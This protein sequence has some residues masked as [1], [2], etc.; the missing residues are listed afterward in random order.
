MAVTTFIPELWS[1]RLKYNLEKNLV[2]ANLV[3]RDY[4]GEIRQAGDTVH[5]NN[6]NP[7]TIRTYAAGTPITVEDL[8]TTDTDLVIS[9]QDYFAFKVEDIDKAQ[10]A[11]DLVDTAMGR[12][13]YGL[14]DN[15]DAYLIGKMA[16]EG[17]AVGTVASMTASNIYPEILKIRKAMDKA[18]VPTVGR[19]L[20]VDPDAYALL[21]ADTTHFINGSEAGADRYTNGYVGKVAGFEVYESNNVTKKLIGG[22]NEAVTYASQV[23]E[24][25]AFRPESSF[26]D[27]VKGLHVYGAKVTRPA[28]IQ[29]T[30]V[31]AYA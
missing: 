14:A 31:T 11:G 28:A 29:V 26:S 21:L 5:I 4:E 1:A 3:N 16:A 17:T 23:S 6:L 24:I 27:A 13:S 10:S 12:A 15:A 2:A 30:T 18:N 22:V 19:W 8:T 20:L 7:I 9:E 25:E